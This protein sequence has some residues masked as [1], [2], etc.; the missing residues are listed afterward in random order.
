[1][2]HTMTGWRPL[3]CPITVNALSSKDCIRFVGSVQ[4]RH[5]WTGL[6]LDGFIKILEKSIEMQCYNW[7]YNK[8]EM[9]S[10]CHCF[11]MRQLWSFVTWHFNTSESS[12]DMYVWVHDRDISQKLSSA[13]LPW[14]VGHGQVFNS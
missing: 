3:T 13:R 11:F 10:K 8:K 5:V 4:I 1:M 14:A 12:F 7:G 2:I 6:R 9:S